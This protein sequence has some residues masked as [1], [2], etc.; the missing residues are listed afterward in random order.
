[1]EGVYLLA[2]RNAQKII[3]ITVL[4][5]NKQSMTLPMCVGDYSAQVQ[6]PANSLL[7]LRIKV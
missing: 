4:N 3:T 5:S 6:L 7:T 2:T 1:M